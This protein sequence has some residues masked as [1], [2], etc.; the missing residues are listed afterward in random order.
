VRL[1]ATTVGLVLAC[2]GCTHVQLA[3]STIGQGS[4]LS[5]LQRRQVLDNL[6]MFTANPNSLAWHLKLRGG[7]V[8]VSDQGSLS[9]NAVFLFNRNLNPNVG[10]QRGVVGQWDVEPAVDVDELES[11]Q[12]AYRL[13]IDP[14][15]AE[16]RLGVYKMVGETAVSHHIILS[17]Q[18]L[19]ALIEALVPDLV[20]RERLRRRNLELRAELHNQTSIIDQLQ[21]ADAARSAA[22]APDA[23]R[24][25]AA[26]DIGPLKAMLESRV[27]TADTAQAW[28]ALTTEA[29]VLTEDKIIKLTQE[30]CKADLHSVPRYPI[31]GRHERNVAIVDQAQEKIDK[32]FELLEDAA[33]QRPWLFVGGKRDVPEMACDVGRCGHCYVWAAPWASRSLTKF[34]LIVLALAPSDDQDI[35]GGGGTANPGGGAAYSPSI[36]SGS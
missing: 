22:F 4:T 31:D 19:N 10:T 13:A 7:L 15:D 17:E 27:L 3:R 33:F 6:A 5:D 14:Q 24:R 8:Q 30:V 2:L 25:A 12:L 11:L 23:D 21:A 16:A 32:L 28:V 29:R 35:S 26:G 18:A 34:V 9:L 20:E 1:R 36:A